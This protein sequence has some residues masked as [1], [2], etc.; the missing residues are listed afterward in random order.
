MR[1]HSFVPPGGRPRILINCAA[2]V[3]GK[4]ANPDGTRAL[5]SGKKD[6]RRVHLMRNGADAILV[7]VGTILADD[8][9]LAVKEEFVKKGRR[10]PLKVVLDSSCRTTRDA[11]VLSSPGPTLIATAEECQESVPG[12][13][14]VRCGKGRVDLGALMK[15][16]A[17]RGVWTVLVEG[18]GITIASFLREGLWDQMTIYYAPVVM[19]GTGGPTVAEGQIVRIGSGP[20]NV[21][22][23]AVRR[24]GEGVL[25]VLVP[26]SQVPKSNPR[27]R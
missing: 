22:L 23:A 19:G 21:H 26:P 6:L 24:L 4:I 3:D 25:V 9:S 13:E 5:L 14:M 12:A 7:G 1:K 2:S 17:S 15:V 18:G 20:A 8:P 16:L 11:R 10:T 27:R